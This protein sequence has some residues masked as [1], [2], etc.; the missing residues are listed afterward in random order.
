MICLAGKLGTLILTTLIRRADQSEVESVFSNIN[1]IYA[2]VPAQRIKKD[3]A[4]CFIY[5]PSNNLEMPF[6]R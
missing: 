4:S 2:R 5:I 1:N 6:L 3:T